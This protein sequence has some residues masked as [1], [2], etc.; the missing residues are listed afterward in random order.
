MARTA[1]KVYLNSQEI[2]W[3]DQITSN[4]EQSRSGMLRTA[5]LAYAKDLGLIRERFHDSLGDRRP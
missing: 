3:L 5:F 2:I 4:L 1:V